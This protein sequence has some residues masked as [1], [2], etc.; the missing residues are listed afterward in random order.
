MHLLNRRSKSQTGTAGRC[1]N[2]AVETANI[3][4]TGNR[5]TLRTTTEADRKDLVRIRSTEE[6]RL[7]WKGTDLDAEFTEDLADEMTVRLT[8]TD[9]DDRIVGLVQFAEEEDPDYRHASIDI[10]IDPA[11]HRQGFA[12]DA[13]RTLVDYLFDV[14]N[15]HRLT[16]DPVADNAAAIAC[17]SSIGFRPV[18]LMRSYERQNDGSW[19]DGLLMDL[20]IDDQRG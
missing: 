12:S 17:Y 16:I 10:Y 11:A 6:V 9:S 8:I 4:L 14:R 3:E 19:S 5:V 18:G 15:H 2:H 20:L 7:R 1:N 13:I